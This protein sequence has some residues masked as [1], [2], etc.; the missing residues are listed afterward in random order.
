MWGLSIDFARALRDSSL[1]VTVEDGVTRARVAVEDG[2]LY[3]RMWNPR[4]AA[5]LEATAKLRGA[6][7]RPLPGY[8][9][10]LQI[11]PQALVALQR[12]QP[13]LASADRETRTRAWI[14][15]AESKASEPYRV[16]RR[17]GR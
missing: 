16:W 8:R 7:A 14:R 10:W 5:M 9:A 15:F 6:E 4:E 2:R 13:E 12:E 17:A 3:R 1:D 11:P